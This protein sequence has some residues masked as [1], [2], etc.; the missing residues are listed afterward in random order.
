MLHPPIDLVRAVPAPTLPAPRAC[1]GGCAYELKFDGWR[2]AAFI[3]SARVVLHSRQSRSLDTYFP[4][5]TAALASHLPAGTVVDGELVV[6]DPNE[7]G[8]GSRS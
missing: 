6:Y 1:R 4:D 7:A 5:I 2:A 8:P 3:D